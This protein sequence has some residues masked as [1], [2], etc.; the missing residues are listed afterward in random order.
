MWDTWETQ[1]KLFLLSSTS[2]RPQTLMWKFPNWKFCSLEN[3]N[4]WNS[5]AFVCFS[6]VTFLLWD[7]KCYWMKRREGKGWR[8]KMVG[9]LS[10]ICNGHCGW[11]PMSIPYQTISPSQWWLLLLQ[12]RTHQWSLPDGLKER[13]Y[14]SSL[15]GGVSLSSTEYED[16]SITQ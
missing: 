2:H 13:T 3:L 5:K 6:S 11:S 15:G 9:S 4:R 1:L 12:V 16:R 8:V 10:N 14:I 7:K